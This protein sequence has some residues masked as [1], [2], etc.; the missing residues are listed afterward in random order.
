[1]N[2][3]CILGNLKKKK[4]IWQEGAGKGIGSEEDQGLGLIIGKICTLKKKKKKQPTIW[5]LG[6]NF[7]GGKMRVAAWET[8]LQV[9]LRNCSREARGNSQCICDFGEGSIYAINPMFYQK[10]PTS[11]LKLCWSWGTVITLKDFSAFLHMRRYQNW[12]HKIGS[13]KYLTIWTPVLPAFPWAQSASFLLSTLNPFQGVLKVSS[14][15]HIWFHP[16]GR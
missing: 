11:F 15:S 12:A 4:S 14:Y 6:L 7:I 16:R 9:A 1:M 8:A 5:E 3:N 10:L 13:W 2:I